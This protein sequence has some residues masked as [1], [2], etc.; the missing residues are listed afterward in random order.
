MLSTESLQACP[1]STHT[2]KTTYSRQTQM[3]LFTGAHSTEHRHALQQFIKGGFSRSYH[4]T[5]ETFMPVLL[6]IGGDKPSAAL[7]IRS[8]VSP[9]FVETYM[10]APVEDMLAQV[11]FCTERSR[12][13]EIGNLYSQNGRF[14]QP[15]LL[16]TALS[17]LQLNHAVMVFTATSAL[18]QLMAK[19]GLPLTFLCEAS[20]QSLSNEGAEWG[21]YYETQPQVVAL[22]T[23][24]VSKLVTSSEKVAQLFNSVAPLLPNI[25]HTLEVYL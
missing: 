25:T 5:L 21:T 10:P 23:S 15:L 19:I 1:T 18:R 8:G 2:A 14:T 3:Q 22:R 17:L 16:L 6:G 11:N 4:A 9:L 7:G 24:E 20:K 12:I 13:V